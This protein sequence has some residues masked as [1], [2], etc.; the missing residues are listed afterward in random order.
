MNQYRAAAP[1]QDGYP[2]EL[3]QGE[4]LLVIKVFQSVGDWQFCVRFLDDRKQP[5]RDLGIKLK[6]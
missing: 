4:N 5:L 1:D 3:R 6:S 2:V